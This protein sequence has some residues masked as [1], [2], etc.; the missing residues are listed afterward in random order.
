MMRDRSR[1]GVLVIIGSL[2]LAGCS[3]IGIRSGTRE[4]AHQVVDR[5]FEAVEVR[6]Y[7]PR[8]VAETSVDRSSGRDGENAAFRR[9]LE[10]I[11]GANTTPAGKPAR[12]AMTAPV[13][14]RGGAQKI[15]MTAPVEIDASGAGGIRGVMR[16]F[17]PDGM[18]MET[19]PRPTD[20][21]VRLVEMPEQTFAVLRFS[22]APNES[23]IAARGQTLVRSLNASYWRPAG[24]PVTWFYDPPWTLWFVRRN[25]VAVPVVPR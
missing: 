5:P 4:P 11:S 23:E 18:T 16:F 3:V 7:A 22:G 12:I 17:L 8:L 13:E 10:Y 1:A 21:R 19:A 24:E 9:L 20:L 25:E 2:L 15:A 14:T 6:A